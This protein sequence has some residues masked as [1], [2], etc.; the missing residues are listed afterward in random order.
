MPGTGHLFAQ[1]QELISNFPFPMKG[2]E[3]KESECELLEM[4]V[5]GLQRPCEERRACRKAWEH[6][7]KQDHQVK[8]EDLDGPG[9]TKTESIQSPPALEPFPSHLFLCSSFL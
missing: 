7:S 8:G 5:F 9:V 3:G 2:D 1:G 6:I 4:V